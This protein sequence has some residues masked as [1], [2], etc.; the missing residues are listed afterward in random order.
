MSISKALSYVKMCRRSRNFYLNPHKD[1]GISRNMYSRA[2]RYDARKVCQDE[3]INYQ[4]YSIVEREALEF[5]QW[6]MEFTDSDIHEISGMWIN[7]DVLDTYGLYMSQEGYMHAQNLIDAYY[8]EQ[9]RA[10][11]E[12]EQNEY[13]YELDEY[14][15]NLER[16]EQESIAEFNDYNFRNPKKNIDHA[17]AEMHDWQEDVA[18][19]DRM[20][21]YDYYESDANDIVSAFRGDWQAEIDDEAIKDDG[22]WF[23]PEPVKYA[24]M[25]GRILTNVTIESWAYRKIA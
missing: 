4:T 12:A 5:E 2:R 6:V 16:E 15:E 13:S 20:V 7:S 22:E 24:P 25:G 11:E 21:E 1:L 3:L 19:F 9:Q 8:A 18:D 23:S 14:Y 10:I 17:F